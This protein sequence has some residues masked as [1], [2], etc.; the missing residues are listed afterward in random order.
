MEMLGPRDGAEPPP[1]VHDLRER[2]EML[3]PGDGAE[4]PPR[5]HAMRR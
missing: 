4:P 2:M 3:G 5:V 1:R